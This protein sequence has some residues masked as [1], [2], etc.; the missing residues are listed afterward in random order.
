MRHLRRDLTKPARSVQHPAGDTPSS[1]RLFDAIANL[2]VPVIVSDDLEIP[3]EGQV[4]V[5]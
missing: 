2:C 1:V 5:R 4:D 3:F